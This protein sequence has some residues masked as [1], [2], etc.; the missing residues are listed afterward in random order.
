MGERVLGRLQFASDV[1][2]S[3]IMKARDNGLPSYNKYR[4]LCN[5][6]VAH[7]FEDFYKWLPKDQA[8]A[9]QMIYEDV[10]DVE[11]MAGLL[12]ERPM[13]AG[14]VGP[15]HACII[16]DQMLRWRRADRFWYE[17]SAHPAAL[18]PEQLKE[19]RKM[20]IA[21]VLCDHGDS[22]DA[23]QPNAFQVPRPGN[24]IIPCSEYPD[25]DMAAWR[26]VSC[27]NKRGK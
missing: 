8:E 25:M 10:E 16:A 14:V 21:K 5:L 6:P 26:D 19:I 23:V 27:T 22:V 20:T 11:V 2:S 4:E 13:G 15:T 3:D 9:F 17:H 18:T 1:M 24:E 7:D 12:A